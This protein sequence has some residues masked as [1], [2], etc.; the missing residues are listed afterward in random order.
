MSL[1]K[2]CMTSLFALI[3]H[4]FCCRDIHKITL[5]TCMCMCK[6]L[7][8]A[9]ALFCFMYMHM[10]TDLHQH[11]FGGPLV[12]Y[13]LKFQ[14]DKDQIFCCRANCKIFL[15]NT[16]VYE[17]KLFCSSQKKRGRTKKFQVAIIFSLLLQIAQRYL[18]LDRYNSVIARDS[19]R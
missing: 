3:A 6:V 4:Y 14:I 12:C 13:E 17:R 8:N 16:V 18:I 11:F 1:Q 7:K 2:F 15:A 19:P 5:N 9:C 10:C